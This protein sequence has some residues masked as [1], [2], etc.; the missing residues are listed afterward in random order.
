MMS[1]ER[2]ITLAISKTQFIA[3]NIT[4]N[5]TETWGWRLKKKNKNT[6]QKDVIIDYL[7]I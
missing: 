2:E 6:K 3:E 4:W 1:D 5:M 7:D